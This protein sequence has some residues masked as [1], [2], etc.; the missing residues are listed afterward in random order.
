MP[1]KRIKHVYTRLSNPQ[2]LQR[3]EDK[4]TQNAVLL[5][6]KGSPTPLNTKFTRKPAGL[7]ALKD[8]PKPLNAKLTESVVLLA[9]K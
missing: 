8:S 7:L 3:C 2:I 6:L 9:V 5:A 4:F 1:Y